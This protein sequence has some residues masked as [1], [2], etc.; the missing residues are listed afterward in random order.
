MTRLRVALGLS[1]MAV[2]G[3]AWYQAVQFNR[4]MTEVQAVQGIGRVHPWNPQV[5]NERQQT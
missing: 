5:S 2:G 3:Y 4:T 1:A